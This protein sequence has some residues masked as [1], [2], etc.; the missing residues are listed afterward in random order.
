MVQIRP[1][2]EEIGNGAKSGGGFVLVV[3]VVVVAKIP[4]STK[5]EK[6]L[7]LST[8]GHLT[9]PY[10]SFHLKFGILYSAYIV[11]LLSPV[12]FAPHIFRISFCPAV[13]R[14]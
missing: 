2:L 5:W 6:F 1:R 12:F 3:V 8:E 9:Y 13:T 10:C 14:H 4:K 7:I 11:H